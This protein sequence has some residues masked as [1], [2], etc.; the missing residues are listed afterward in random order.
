MGIAYAWKYVVGLWL[1]RVG[2]VRDAEMLAS[3]LCRRDPRLTSRRFVSYYQ[4]HFVYVGCANYSL[5]NIVFG[6]QVKPSQPLLRQS[7]LA[8]RLPMIPNCAPQPRRPAS[9]P[10]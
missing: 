3:V 2:F 5:V 6:F 10:L 1:G 8:S 9:W 4:G 7:S